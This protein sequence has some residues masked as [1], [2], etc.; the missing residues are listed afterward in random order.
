MPP[1]TQKSIL[2]RIACSSTIEGFCV[3]KDIDWKSPT[4]GI[5]KVSQATLFLFSCH[6]SCCDKVSFFA[7]SGKAT[8]NE[9]V[10]TQ[11][12]I[13]SGYSCQHVQLW[14]EQGCLGI[15]PLQ[16]AGR[17][18]LKDVLLSLTRLLIT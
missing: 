7:G 2:K 11:M 3:F 4:D 17:Y 14:R 8:P 16:V 9:R 1:R 6:S 10:W 13:D 15:P 5:Y 12:E 18:S